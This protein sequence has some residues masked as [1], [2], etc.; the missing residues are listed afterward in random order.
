LLNRLVISASLSLNYLY[1]VTLRSLH[2]VLQ[3][4]SDDI[5]NIYVIFV[6]CYYVVL[7]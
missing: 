6:I 7:S 3:K 5:N 2:Y 4:Y 1:I